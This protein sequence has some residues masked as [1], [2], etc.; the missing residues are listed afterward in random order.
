[1]SD[2]PSCEELAKQ[3][4]ECP[5]KSEDILKVL[6]EHTTD[7]ILI[8]DRSSKPFFFNDAY[9]AIIKKALGIE[10]RP[11]LIPHKLLTDSS[12]VAW[13]DSHHKRVLSGESFSIEY[14]LEFDENDIRHYEFIFTPIKINGA[15]E[16]FTEISRDITER[17]KIEL[18]LQE[19]H[20]EL[21][22]LVSERSKELTQKT[23][24]LEE[25]N[26]AL[27]V[28]LE[29]REHDNKEIEINF[30][31]KI[32][33]LVIP[34]LEK[35]TTKKTQSEIKTLVEIIE[36]HLKEIISPSALKFSKVLSRL[37]PTENKIADLVRLGKTTKEIAKLL[38]QS[39]ATI[40]THRQNIRKKLGLTNKKINL[41]STLTK[42]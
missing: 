14:A 8:C 1:M 39:P 25:A 22:K 21:E 3:V 18:Q 40:A 30:L 13:W 37:T 9:A 26:V 32:D 41:Q 6:Q 19:H 27:K 16:G 35:L 42:K 29:Q 2:K 17:K 38:N 10:M 4:S 7:Y 33:K 24:H 31:N 28:L 36:S 20:K 12:A 23:K 34:Y 5:F 11:R 15:V